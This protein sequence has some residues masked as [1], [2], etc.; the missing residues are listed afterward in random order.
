M[1]AELIKK[2]GRWELDR[3]R[4]YIRPELII[5]YFISLG[6]KILIWIIGNSFIKYAQ[7]I[8][9]ARTLTEHLSFDRSLYKLV[10]FSNIKFNWRN[11]S[12]WVQN[13]IKNSPLPDIVILHLG[14]DEI[15]FIRTTNLIWDIRSSFSELKSMLPF[16]ILVVLEIFPRLACSEKHLRYIEKIQIRINRCLEKFHFPLWWML[17]KAL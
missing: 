4:I 10:W 14:G 12:S 9:T 3:Y 11:I 8:Y 6:K 15:G 7:K 5:L 1:K 2:L 13:F 17:I 16:S